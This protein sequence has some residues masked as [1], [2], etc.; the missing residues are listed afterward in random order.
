MVADFE[1]FM[2]TGTRRNGQQ[3]HPFMPM[4]TM[5]AMNDIELQAL[6]AYL[7]SVP[8]KPMGGR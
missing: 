3:V 2:R 1:K 7:Q 4:E 8:A 5:K 6:W